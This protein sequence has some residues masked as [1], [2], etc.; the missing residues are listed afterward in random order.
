VKGTNHPKTKK[1][2][3]RGKALFSPVPYNDPN[4]N[5]TPN[6]DISDKEKCMK[7]PKETTG[8]P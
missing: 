2:T 4:I 6:S 1:G 8:M 5:E 7:K 3:S